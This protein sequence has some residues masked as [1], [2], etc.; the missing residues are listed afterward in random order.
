MA[1]SIAVTVSFPLLFVRGH[2]RWLPIFAIAILVAH[3]GVE[4]VCGRTGSL[5]AIPLGMAVSTAIVLVVVLRKLGALRATSPLL[6]GAGAACG[7]LAVVA[8]GGASWLPSHLAA[9]A[10][11]LAAYGAVLAVWRPRGI[12]QAWA[13]VHELQ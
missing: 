2:V 9:A 13:Y 4:W 5:Y 3:G 6:L 8:F 7:G 12:R 10:V 1:T 11:G